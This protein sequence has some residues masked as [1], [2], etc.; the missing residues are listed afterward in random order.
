[1]LGV[2]ALANALGKQ[3]PA[4]ALDFVPVEVP[5]GVPQALRRRP[6]PGTETMTGQ[7]VEDLRMVIPAFSFQLPAPS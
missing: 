6:R 2:I 4:Q 3:F 7:F 5:H 1:M